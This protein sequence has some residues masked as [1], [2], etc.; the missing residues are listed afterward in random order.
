VESFW[1]TQA[2]WSGFTGAVSGALEDENMS[3]EEGEL[4]EAEEEELESFLEAADVTIDETEVEAA[5][6]TQKAV[7]RPGRV[8]A[9]LESRGLIKKGA[10]IPISLLTKLFKSTKD[11]SLKAAFLLAIRF[12]K[13]LKKKGVV[14]G[15]QGQPV[16]PFTTLSSELLPVEQPS[17]GGRKMSNQPDL[18]KQ[19]DEAIKTKNTE[20]TAKNTEITNLTAKNLELAKQLQE[21]GLS[22]KAHEE[23]LGVAHLEA[24]YKDAA[25]ENQRLTTELT[26]TKAYGSIVEDLYRKV[27]VSKIVS[28]RLE[29][30]VLKPNE[31]DGYVAEAT[32]LPIDK[33]NERLVE[34]D[35][36]AKAMRDLGL[37]RRETYGAGAALQA[38]RKDFGYTVGDLSGV[39]GGKQ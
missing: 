3:E 18:Q 37:G 10:L 29:G 20:L 7:K 6:W 11:R 13:G 5:K 23:G 31:V 17:N 8:R 39:Y 30:G 16:Q 27:M 22:L 36:F 15:V 35:R 33:L 25:L 26:N 2:A 19:F 4:D 24:K 28:A 9:Y 34:A 21:A 32:K 38:P 1:E 14:G 12:K